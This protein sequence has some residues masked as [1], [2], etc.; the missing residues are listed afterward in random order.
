LLFS[1]NNYFF[2]EKKCPSKIGLK[3]FTPLTPRNN[4]APMYAQK[5][6]QIA[7]FWHQYKP[8]MWQNAYHFAIILQTFLKSKLADHALF[9]MVRYVLL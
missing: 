4:L 3:N 5:L 9:K 7:P 6:L 2:F 1:K 8:K